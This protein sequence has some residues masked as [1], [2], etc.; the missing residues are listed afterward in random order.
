LN[1]VKQGERLQKILSAYG[2][3][4]RRKAEALIV[5][6]RVCING[7]PATLGQSA[8]VGVDEITVDGVLLTDL[9]EHV[10]IML[11]KPRGYLTTVSDE[12]DRRTVMELVASVGC[13]VYPIGRLDMYSEGLLLFTNDGDFANAVMHPSFEKPKTYIVKARGDLRKALKLLKEPI[14]IDEYTVQAL[15]VELTQNNNDNGLFQISIS[16]GRNRQIRKMCNAC[17]LTVKSLKRISIGSL[18]LGSLKSG[19]WRFLT[20]DEV[21]A[22]G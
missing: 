19:Q 4:S 11:N 12:R 5:E 10:Y 7:S 8:R 21:L 6:G 3:V 15:N 16:E 2:V 20:K 1:T 22:L 9:K 13:R 18:E 17:G 14:Q